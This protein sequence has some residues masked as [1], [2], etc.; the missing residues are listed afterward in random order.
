[1]FVSKIVFWS[2]ILLFLSTW[3]L[4]VG[5]LYIIR[6]VFKSFSD[7]SFV[8]DHRLSVSFIVAAH[9]EEDVIG[10]RIENL[11][12]LD[13]PKDLM[14]IIVGSDGSR[15]STNDVV[16]QLALED[17]RIILLT[18]PN[19]EGR[20][21]IH[22]WCISVAKGDIII[23]TDAETEFDLGFVQEIMPN[24]LDTEVGCVSGRIFYKNQKDSSITEA[25]GIYWEYEE[26]IRRLESDL[27]ILAFG[28]GAALAVRREVYE[29]IGPTEDVDRVTTLNARIKGYKVRYEPKAKAYDYIEA[30]EKSAYNARV[31]KTARAFRDVLCRLVK[32]NPVKEPGLF[33]AVFFHKTSRHLTPY[34]MIFFFI[35]NIFLL[36]ENGIYISIFVL[37]LIF[38]CL[39]FLGFILE[40]RRL[41][42]LP[43][44]LPYNFVLL[45]AGRFSGVLK[46]I[47]GA[48]VSTYT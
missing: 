18:F 28:T 35:L 24:F 22:N 6:T 17:E 37:Q 41:R 19:Q 46:S 5:F 40:K 16:R 4:Y 10:K 12:S 13:Y 43:F 44:Y 38:Y 9:N 23:F 25:A 33:L 15:D 34:Y 30:D 47:F 14:E 2:A 39:A 8:C 32:I 26:L 20:A 11:V 36:G 27:G 7:N 21:Y 3:V 1:M 48:R 42:L 45:N 29:P 31:R